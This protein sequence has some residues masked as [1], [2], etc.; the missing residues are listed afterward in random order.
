M[1]LVVE[2]PACEKPA[3]LADLDL[4]ASGVEPGRF[5]FPCPGCGRYVPVT[6]RVGATTKKAPRWATPEGLL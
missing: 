1:P 6:V 5:A 3:E 2:C 4:V